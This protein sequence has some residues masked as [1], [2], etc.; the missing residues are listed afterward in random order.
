MFLT[1]FRHILYCGFFFQLP[2]SLFSFI[3]WY[4]LCILVCGLG[5]EWRGREDGVG[6]GHFQCLGDGGRYYLLTYSLS[7]SA[8]DGAEIHDVSPPTAGADGAEIRVVSA[9]TSAADGTEIHV[10]STNPPH[11]EIQMDVTTRRRYY[12]F[13][14]ALLTSVSNSQ[15]AALFEDRKRR[16]G[17]DDDSLGVSCRCCGRCS[18]SFC[19]CCSGGSGR[20]GSIDDEKNGPSALSH[21]CGDPVAVVAKSKRRRRG[22]ATTRVS[23]AILQTDGR[24]F[25]GRLRLVD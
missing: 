21:L 7:T 14:S 22:S 1:I 19:N 8:A 12:I 16:R 2:R 4:L 23:S 17:A 15:S 10:V 13:V 24:P 9:P 6:G 18:G 25:N 11:R 3:L 20:S 5:W